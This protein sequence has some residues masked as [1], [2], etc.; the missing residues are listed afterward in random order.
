L[1]SYFRIEVILQPLKILYL[2]PISGTCL[3]RANAIRRLGHNLTH[4]DLRNLLPNT[5][6]VDRF[7]WKVGGDLFAPW[8]LSRLPSHLEGQ[9]FDICYV[10]GGEWVT[11]KVIQLLRQFANRV[12]N[13][14]IDDPYGSRDGARSKAYRK[15]V[16][17]YDLMVV[18]REENI[19][20]AIRLGAKNVMHVYRAADE[21]NHAPRVLTEQD[22]Q[23]WDS[24]VLFLGTWMPER[25]PF[26]VSLIQQGIP[27]TIRGGRWQKA[28][29][30]A[31]L[32]PY[33]KGGS[34][35]GDE[36]AKAIQCA[37]INIGLLSKGNRDLHT[38]RSAEIPAIGSLFCAERTR[39][40]LSMYQEGVEALF[41]KDASEC[42]EMCKFALKNET[43]RQAIAQAGR[44]R[45]RLNG[46][47][48]EPTSQ[49]IIE[50]A[51]S[52]DLQSAN[53][54]VNVLASQPA[55]EPLVCE[56]G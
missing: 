25:G 27:L 21:I 44:E 37:K 17:Y 54:V 43:K 36:Y 8:V 19:S 7:T 12:I 14:N 34:I 49:Q 47:Y 38:T 51:M 29:E 42:A 18:V 31:L 53:Y 32:E 22:H 39:D 15:S 16:P 10:D 41:W 55:S 33:W 52:L 48:N 5:V 40:H 3:D 6:W 28:P 50:K 20:E 1:L 11:P 4:L 13:Y 30:W 23:T 46:H 24:D 56:K 45:L 9:Y 35:A 26:L 2:G